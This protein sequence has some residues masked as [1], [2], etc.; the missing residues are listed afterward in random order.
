MVVVGNIASISSALRCDIKVVVVISL[1]G[2]VVD[3]DMVVVVAAT[4]SQEPPAWVRA[5]RYSQDSPLGQ[6]PPQAPV[7]GF[8]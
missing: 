8:K 2:I 6:K 5:G 7:L 1:D 3:W 4:H